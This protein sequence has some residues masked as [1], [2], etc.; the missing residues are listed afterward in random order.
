[1]ASMGGEEGARGD[2]YARASM[3]GEEEDREAMRVLGRVWEARRVLGLSMEN[4]EG[5]RASMHGR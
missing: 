5:A 2:E 1:M 3:G 4:E